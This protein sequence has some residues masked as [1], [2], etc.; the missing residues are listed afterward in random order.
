KMAMVGL[1]WYELQ[2]WRIAAGKNADPKFSALSVVI[3]T[4][5]S[6]GWHAYNKRRA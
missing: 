1:V 4:I 5:L 2:M 3:K 6:A